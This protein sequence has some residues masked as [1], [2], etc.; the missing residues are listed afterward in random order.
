MLEV[1]RISV[2]YGDIQVIFDLSLAVG[3]REI[4]TLIGANGAGK[5]TTVN[6][7]SGIL[8]PSSGDIRYRGVSILRVPP[9]Q[10][11]EM[12]LVQVPEGRMLFPRLT[13]RQ[14]L[15]IGSYAKAARREL[16]KRME[17]VF[18]LFPPLRERQSQQVSTMSG[19]EQQMLAIARGL[20]SSPK[21]LILDEP[22]TGLAPVLVGEMFRVVREINRNNVSI[23]LIEQNAMQALQRSHRGYVL[24]HGHLAYEGSAE[25]LLNND[26]VRS[27]YLG[28]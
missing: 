17:W 12:G 6:T 28:I 18:E 8:R 25:S 22:S 14:N 10:L 27:A 16:D 9:H 5:T 19:G 7:I 3:A 2:F 13:V 23:L 11:V 1:E 24:E 4:V 20:M 15:K 21:L 26:M